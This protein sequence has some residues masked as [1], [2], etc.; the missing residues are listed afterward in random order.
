M[1]RLPD[2]DFGKFGHGDEDQFREK[3]VL[4]DLCAAAV[5]VNIGCAPRVCIGYHTWQFGARAFAD[6]LP[7]IAERL[8]V[9]RRS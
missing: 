6:S 1:P 5:T 7:W 3:G 8:G 4:P 2:P 9:C